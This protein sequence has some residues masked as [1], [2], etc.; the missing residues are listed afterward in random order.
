MTLTY[1]LAA[2]ADLPFIV[3]LIDKNSVVDSGEDLAHPD[4]P[5][6][7]AAFDTIA[8]DPNQ[9]LYI[10]EDEGTRVGTFQ[11]T[12]IPGI[13][14]RGTWRALIEG[15]Y[16]AAG[17]RNRGY[18]SQMMRFAIER[19]RERCC[20]IV[21]LTSNKARKDAHRFYERLGFVASHEGF[22]LKLEDNYLAAIGA[23]LTEWNE[24]EDDEASRD[25]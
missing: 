5:G 1:R 12:F 16:I 3:G 18:G 2:S 20:G 17:F 21:Q 10:A 25:P 15:V 6:Y 4:G 11:L 8:A 24:P 9:N 13:S 14:R 7:R 23:T 22:K 19:C